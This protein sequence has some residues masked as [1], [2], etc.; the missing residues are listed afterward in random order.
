MYAVTDWGTPSCL[1]V[2]EL[3]SHF[4]PLILTQSGSAWSPL[5]V[6]RYNRIQASGQQFLL[7][8]GHY[9]EEHATHW[10]WCWGQLV[11]VIRVDSAKNEI[12][13]DQI[14]WEVDLAKSSGWTTTWVHWH[15]WR[16]RCYHEVMLSRKL[17][18]IRIKRHCW[19]GLWRFLI[20]DRRWRHGMGS[21]WNLY[22]LH[23]T[24]AF[25]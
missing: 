16:W 9:Q 7:T 23:W 5:L 3:V 4:S 20:G 22:V 25:C 18:I 11:C 19:V 15:G 1:E 24:L 2:Y 21:T 17:S 14:L 13:Q 6:W 10:L 8:R 12:G